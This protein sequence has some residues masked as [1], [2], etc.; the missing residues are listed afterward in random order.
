MGAAK[1]YLL[2]MMQSDTATME[3]PLPFLKAAGRT[4][5]CQEAQGQGEVWAGAT[6]RHLPPCSW[7]IGG[8]GIWQQGFGQKGGLLSPQLGVELSPSSS[9]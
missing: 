7:S 6:R 3:L 5:H 9:P 1:M 4:V 2:R 8:T